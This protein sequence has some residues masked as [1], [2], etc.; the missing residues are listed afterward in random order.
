[1]ATNALPDSGRSSDPG[2]REQLSH[3]RKLSGRARSAARHRERTEAPPAGRPRQTG[4]R[5][6]MYANGTAA[7][8]AVVGSD[9]PVALRT[10]ERVRLENATI[11]AAV[12]TQGRQPVP[13]F[14]ECSNGSCDG[15]LWLP[16]TDYDQR[17]QAGEQ[18]LVDG[19]PC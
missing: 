8:A 5:T 14:C 16:L 12:R 13:F 1:M 7:G 10:P 17:A 15:A 4:A 9:Y 11:R 19:H 2:L 18:I 6:T 3:R